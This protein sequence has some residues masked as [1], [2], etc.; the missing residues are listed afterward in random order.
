VVV[1]R[2]EGEAM[3]PVVVNQ[4]YGPFAIMAEFWLVSR[5]EACDDFSVREGIDNNFSTSASLGQ[6]A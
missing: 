3:T 1:L 6:T 5:G 2:A 4:F